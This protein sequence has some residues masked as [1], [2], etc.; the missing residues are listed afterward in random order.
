MTGGRTCQTT[1]DHRS[2]G[3][4]ID[5]ASGGVVEERNETVGGAPLGA[6]R[7]P[8]LA[9]RTETDQPSQFPMV[10]Y[11]RWVSPTTR[12]SHRWGLVSAAGRDAPPSASQGVLGREGGVRTNLGWDWYATCSHSGNPPPT[13]RALSG[14]RHAPS[15]KRGWSHSTGVTPR[16]VHYRGTDVHCRGNVAGI[17]LGS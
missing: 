5:Q 17:I 10:P 4:F 15:G 16:D 2:L 11:V 7:V 12:T 9:S 1:T 6:G 14:N 13:R 8:G 3:Q